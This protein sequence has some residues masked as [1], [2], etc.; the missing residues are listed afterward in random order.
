[1]CGSDPNPVTNDHHWL[2]RIWIR[3][4]TLKKRL[5][6]LKKYNPKQTF[7]NYKQTKSLLSP[8]VSSLAVTFWV[9]NLL[10]G[11]NV[12]ICGDSELYYSK[13]FVWK[14]R[15]VKTLLKTLGLLTDILYSRIV[16]N[17]Y[18]FCTFSLL[19]GKFSWRHRQR[20]NIIKMAGT[21]TCLVL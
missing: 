13:K 10:V 14:T 3:I 8:N 12:R 21:V 6:L 2:T 5:K 9:T 20:D 4:L 18:L 16:L 1:M 15:N 7:N 19:S 11:N 17:P